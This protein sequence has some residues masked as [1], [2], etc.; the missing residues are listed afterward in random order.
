MDRRQKKLER[1]R[2]QR[3]V[4]KKRKRVA[5][6]AR[7]DRE[8]RLIAAASRAPLGPCFI[9]V[10]WDDE[11][12]ELPELVNVVVTRRL[13]EGDLIATVALVDRTCLGIKDAS[14][15]GPLSDNELDEYVDKLGAAQEMQPCEP[16]VAQSVVYHALDYAGRLGF[17]PHRDFR[18]E[19]FGPRP[20]TLAATP[21]HNLA[22]PLFVSG[23]YDNVGLV[24]ARLEAAVGSGNFD[25]MAFA[26]NEDEDE[27]E[28]VIDVQAKPPAR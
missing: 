9:G 24:V 16:E 10:E 11:A 6:T 28:D 14:V 8:A 7:P 23:P 19:L 13:A 22:R 5:E 3:A 26:G 4:A 18:E 17:G 21:W 25:V 15:A 12:A 1:K 20:E 27:D 2:K